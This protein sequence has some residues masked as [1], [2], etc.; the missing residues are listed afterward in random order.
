M[1][2]VEERRVGEGGP[3]TQHDGG[4]DLI[5]REFRPHRENRGVLHVR[6]AH[7]YLLHFKR[8]DIFAAAANGIL[9]AVHEAIKAVVLAHYPVAAVKP[10]IAPGFDRL[11]RHA[12]IAGREGKGLV[13][14]QHQFTGFAVGDLIV[15]RVN[16]AGG[17]AFQQP[18]H[19]AGPLFGQRRPHDAVR[20]RRTVSIK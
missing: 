8:G 10:K 11:F 13:G 1:A 16:N 6:M 4:H 9:H 20:F 3:A 19:H 12:E 2:I 17:E 7:Q 14:A 15:L 5:F 18:P